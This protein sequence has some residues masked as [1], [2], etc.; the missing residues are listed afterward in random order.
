[1]KLKRKSKLYKICA[2]LR[3]LIVKSLTAG[4]IKGFKG[5][6][7]TRVV[8]DI[9]ADS[10]VLNHM[11]LA[12]Y[13]EVF[14]DKKLIV[15]K[16]FSVNNYSRIMCKESIKIGDN[17]VLAQFVSILDHDHLYDSNT[18]SFDGYLSSPISIGNNVWIGDRVTITK[19]VSIG[20]NVIVGANSVVTHNIP[21]NVVAVG[22]PA[23]VIKRL[24]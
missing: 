12:D 15:G 5:Q 21:S 8:F 14:S 6:I 19:G 1:M 9:N 7:G 16:N 23:K 17:V 20:D 13:V 2:L 22:I 18:S 3:Y 24:E 11:I 4:T 10:Q